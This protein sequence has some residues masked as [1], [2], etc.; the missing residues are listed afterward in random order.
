M[1]VWRLASSVWTL[2]LWLAIFA[3][4]LL[5][6]QPKLHEKSKL[7]SFLCH[8]ALASPFIALSSRFLVNDT[9]IIHVAA[10]GG[11]ALPLKY[12]FAA[13]WAAR[14]GP[15]LLWVLWM[16]LLSWIWRKPLSGEDIEGHTAQQIRLRLV[17]GFSLLLLVI[18]LI[19]DPFK[20]N[21]NEW[22]GRGLNELLQ[23]DLMVIHPPLVFLSYS[24]CLHIAAIS[25]SSFYSGNSE[26][27]QQRILT[28]ARPALFFATLG[29][30]L[31]GLW[32][33]LILDWG[34]Y[35]AWD[36]VETGSFLPWLA[37]VVIVHLRTRPGKTPD[38][39]WIGAGLVAG[40]LAIF[41]TLVT[42]A[43]GVWASSV[44]TFVVNDGG[45]P[46]SEVFGRFMVLRGEAAGVEV[47][48][49]LVIILLFVGVW[50]TMQRRSIRTSEINQNGLYLFFIPLI[51]AIFAFLFELRIYSLIPV[52]IF[53]ILAYSHLI[54]DISSD[55]ESKYSL[56][57]EWQFPASKIIPLLLLAPIILS[58]I[59]GDVLFSLL[60]LIFFTPMFYSINPAKQWGWATGGIMLALASAWS[61]LVDLPIAASVLI[62]FVSPW[63]LVEDDKTKSSKGF[64]ITTRKD[65]Q[66]MAL[67]ATVVVSGLYLILTLAILLASIDSVNLSA[68]E[69]YGAPFMLAIAI[70]MFTYVMRKEEPKTVITV[71]LSV[72]VVS[73]LLSVFAPEWL[74]QDSQT[75][76]SEYITRGAIAWISLP[77]LL[78][79]MVPMVNEVFA[80]I[81]RKTRTPVLKRIPVGAHIVHLGLILLMVGHIF[82]TTLVNR[83]DASHRVS[84]VQDEIIIHGDY[85]YQFMEII[86]EDDGL[87][88]GDGYVGIRIA[89]YEMDENGDGIIEYSKIATVEPGML[90]F[91]STGTARSEVDTLS[92]WHGDIVFIFDG[93]QANG[94]MQQARMDGLDSIEMVRVTIYDLPNSH[95]VWS[96]W[97]LMLIGMAHIAIISKRKNNALSDDDSQIE[98]EE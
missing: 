70:A 95:L 31:G 36:P 90:R 62:I 18:S 96:G 93:S 24:L 9:S 10:Y 38:N 37:L 26:N 48:S 20:A 56:P 54:F 98:Q 2:T 15:I 53:P 75:T 13:T 34:G 46:P 82:T 80:Q 84:L 78:V 85:G 5:I 47:M 72:F 55:K 30:G 89:V 25:I 45:T 39:V 60:C 35:W 44:H 29:I 19:L 22:I 6:L 97:S 86:L 3:A 1:K 23:T 65:Q 74:G 43:G 81:Q 88:V 63:L 52:F 16:S 11:A 8:L 40:T 64:D 7:L 73:I 58:F 21:E 79:T 12:R 67:W 57:L 61:G 42:R 91:D 76:V 71:V 83:E 33:Y 51:L 28:I 66:R 32:A 27:I 77:M 94:L 17:H 14:E 49:Y 69:L 4:A 68:H 50:L 59:N 87:E 92:R 41:A